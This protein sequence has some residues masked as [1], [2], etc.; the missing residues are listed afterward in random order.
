[1]CDNQYNAGNKG[2]DA[3]LIPLTANMLEHVM[4]E[5]VLITN[6]EIRQI[7]LTQGKHA[8]V[9]LENFE[10][11]SQWSW[12]FHGFYA[13]RKPYNA[14]G[15]C[16]MMHRLIINAPED[17]YVDHINGNGLDNRR[18]NLRLC[19][20]TQNCMNSLRRKNKTSKYKGVSWSKEK[21]KWAVY[22]SYYKKHSFVGRYDTEIE[23]A[24]AYNEA[25]LKYHG[26]F[27]KLNEIEGIHT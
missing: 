20:H 11:L 1:M 16:F 26:E 3:H 4:A 2:V 23:A 17:M 12:Y 25:A 10:R 9:D 14:N 6:P 8:I 18:S 7:P 22:I 24:L 27:A 19:T 13:V 5:N 21:E 15:K